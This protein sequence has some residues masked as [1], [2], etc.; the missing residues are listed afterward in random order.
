[1]TEDRAIEAVRGLLLGLLAE[2]GITSQAVEPDTSIVD[3]LGFDSLDFVDLTLEL[4]SAM[5]LEEFPI[6]QWAD[7]QMDQAPPRFTVRALALA[8]LAAHSKASNG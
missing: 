8:G 5:G 7:I 4:E 6:Q 1:M 2:R 3:D